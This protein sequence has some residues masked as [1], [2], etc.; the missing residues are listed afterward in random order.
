MCSALSPLLSTAFIDE[1]IVNEN[2]FLRDV[3][4][5]GFEFPNNQSNPGFEKWIL[6]GQKTIKSDDGGETISSSLKL[7]VLSRNNITQQMLTANNNPWMANLIWGKIIRSKSQNN[8]VY[9]VASSF[10]NKELKVY[11]IVLNAGTGGVSSVTEIQELSYSGPAISKFEVSPDQSKIVTSRGQYFHF[12]AL[13]GQLVQLGSGIDNLFSISNPVFS[14][15]SKFVYLFHYNPGSARFYNLNRYFLGDNCDLVFQKAIGIPTRE[16]SFRGPSLPNLGPDDLIYFPNIQNPPTLQGYESSII[17]SINNV[18][19]SLPGENMAIDLKKVRLNGTKITSNMA[20]NRVITP[21]G[22]ESKTM[23]TC[24]SCNNVK[25][26][27]NYQSPTM[28]IDFGDG[29]TLSGTT[30]G[31]HNYNCTSI[32]PCSLLVKILDVQ[33][34][35]TTVIDQK[36]IY[37]NSPSIPIV[38]SSTSV[39]CGE[40]KTLTISNPVSFQTYLWYFQ[41]TD[42]NGNPLGD[43]IAIESL[44]GTSIT[45]KFK[46]TGFIQ[47]DYGQNSCRQVIN[48]PIQFNPQV[49]IF[50]SPSPQTICSGTRTGIGINSLAQGASFVW[51]ILAGNALISGAGPGNGSYLNQ[52]LILDPTTSLP[53]TLSYEITASLSGCI[54]STLMVPVTVKPIPIFSALPTNYTICNNT[55]ANVGITTFP[56]PLAQTYAWTIQNEY[57]VAG[58]EPCSTGCLPLIN[59]QLSVSNPEKLLLTIIPVTYNITAT[60]NG[61]SSSIPLIV[62][63]IPMV[64][65]GVC[66]DGAKRVTFQFANPSELNSGWTYVWEKANV[67]VS[68]SATNFSSYSPSPSDHNLFLN[69]GFPDQILRITGGQASNGST[70]TN[71][72]RTLGELPTYSGALFIDNTYPVYLHRENIDIEGTAT[73]I[74][75]RLFGVGYKQYNS[76]LTGGSCSDGNIIIKPNS[77]IL[78][79]NQAIL[80][81]SCQNMWG[82]IKLNPPVGTQ[83]ASI[84]LLNS[85]IENAFEGISSTTPWSVGS[86][87]NVQNSR[88][89]SCMFGIKTGPVK[90]D[91]SFI[92][93]NTFTSDHLQMRA[94]FDFNRNKTFLRP[95]STVEDG[96]FLTEV[97]LW[98]NSVGALNPVQFNTEAQFKNNS[99]DNVAIGILSESN[100]AVIQK[101][102]FSNCHLVAILGVGTTNESFKDNDIT[103]PLTNNFR[104]T[105]QLEQLGTTYDCNIAHPGPLFSYGMFFRQNHDNVYHNFSNNVIRSTS[106]QVN[107]NHV[108]ISNNGWSQNAFYLGNTLIGLSFGIRA[109]RNCYLNISKNTFTNNEIAIGLYHRSNAPNTYFRLDLKCNTLLHEA[110]SGTARKGLVIGQNVVVGSYEPTSPNNF[111]QNHIGGNGSFNNGFYYPNANVWP[112]AQLDRSYSPV[113]DDQIPVDIDD[114]VFGWQDAQYWTAI[115]NNSA[116][117]ITYFGYKNEFFKNKGSQ[118]PRVLWT[119]PNIKIATQ[120]NPSLDPNSTYEFACDRPQDPWPILFPARIAVVSGLSDSEKAENLNFLGDPI[121]NPAKD[122]CKI[123]FVLQVETEQAVLQVLELGTGRILQSIEIKERGKGEIDLDLRQASSGIYSYRLLM[124]GK[125]SIPKKLAITR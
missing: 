61:C 3:L 108:G 125:P 15:N 58:A 114:P 40:T 95:G 76:N 75:T 20:V 63:L 33:A 106:S 113:D 51:D 19:P 50:A 39:T 88:F 115:E 55:T 89:E 77:S 124:N 12:D 25:V 22:T 71:T 9:L 78:V 121:P 47:I 38:N 92:F 17:G 72:F 53:Q 80:G 42:G 7:G 10:G 68:G 67:P 118:P 8:H 110:A 85:T 45:Y 54:N 107:K 52:E 122:K 83:F 48:I 23:I 74:G 119:G 43:R 16:P 97:G 120:G 64:P 35:V 18:E 100:G 41:P 11:R 29:T 109:D 102:N 34:G 14:R 86:L 21:Y 57:G 90:E 94:P 123:G 37:L 44:N 30:F 56:F 104:T 81:S 24:V 79:S 27:T 82:G 73:W 32:A 99:F 46:T 65:V 112:T 6:V 59:Q 26:F 60:L 49:S 66:D 28:V 103:L 2:Y 116:N 98:T 13:A 1:Q 84:N 101:N 87:L 4:D 31:E 93:G 36:L 111:R 117:T 105:F 5:I 70:C 62:K 69:S 96:K 91:A